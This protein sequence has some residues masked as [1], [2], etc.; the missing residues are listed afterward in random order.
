ME[1]TLFTIGHIGLSRDEFF[2]KLEGNGIRALI[3]IRIKSSSYYQP[4]AGFSVGY[5]KSMGYPMEKQNEFSIDALKRK[6]KKADI[7]YLHIPELGYK[8]PNREIKTKEDFDKY[9][10]DYREALDDDTTGVDGCA[11]LCFFM[12]ECVRPI[13]EGIP[14]ALMGSDNRWRFCPRHVLAYHIN[15]YISDRYKEYFIDIVH[16]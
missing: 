9:I 12:P 11:P 3:D 6:C 10:A 4:W 16:L 7:D 2:Q 13:L 14:T 1:Y 8:K 5:C 15:G